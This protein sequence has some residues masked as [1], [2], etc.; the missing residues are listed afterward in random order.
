MTKKTKKSAKEKFVRDLVERG[1]AAVPD[2][3]GKMPPGAT[4]EIVSE[5][6]KAQPVVKRR[7]FSIRR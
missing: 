5:D 3:E 4:H 6:E 1:E 7:R 2:E